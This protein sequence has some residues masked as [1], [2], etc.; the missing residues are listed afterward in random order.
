[1]LVRNSVE[2][3]LLRKAK[4]GKYNELTKNPASRIIELNDRAR[5]REALPPR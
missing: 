5:K 3:T 4:F 1:L 2:P